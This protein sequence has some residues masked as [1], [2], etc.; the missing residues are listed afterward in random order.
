MHRHVLLDGRGG[1]RI[2][3]R[4]SISDFVNVYSHSHD[5]RDARDVRRPQTVIGDGV[6]IAYHATVLAGATLA[7]DSMVGAGAIVTR[8]T[9]PG[10]VHVGVP[11]RPATRK[12]EGE[13][14][15]PTRDPLAEE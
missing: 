14:R 11:A 10:T 1:I 3:D 15:P 2:G 8:N 13:R 5:I 4:A 9:E 6:R 7:P 12:P